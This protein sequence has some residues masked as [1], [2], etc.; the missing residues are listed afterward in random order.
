MANKLWDARREALRK[1]LKEVRK[2]SSGLTQFELSAVLGKPQS[3]V[4]KYETGERKL[5][6]VEVY[7][8]CEALNVSME[9]FNRL[10]ESKICGIM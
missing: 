2:E 3:Y 4:S 6:Y 10:Y 1:L 8:I 9:E 7:E 5:D